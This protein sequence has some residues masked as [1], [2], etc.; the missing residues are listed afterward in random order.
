MT[1]QPNV[2]QFNHLSNYDLFIDAHFIVMWALMSFALIWFT[3][4]MAPPE[5]R[6]KKGKFR[7]W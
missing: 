3:Y 7:G 2:L 4:E 6:S 1:N 5:E